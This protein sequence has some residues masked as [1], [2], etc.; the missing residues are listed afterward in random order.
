MDPKPELQAGF[1]GASASSKCLEKKQRTWLSLSTA[2]KDKV[3]LAGIEYSDTS[4][5]VAKATG[6]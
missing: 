2:F 6:L 1:R 5:C 4:A 3:L